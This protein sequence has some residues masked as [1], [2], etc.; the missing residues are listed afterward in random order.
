MAS[1][2][3][4]RKLF[5]LGLN[6]EVITGGQM[7][8]ALGKQGALSGADGQLGKADVL[9]KPTTPALT[10]QTKTAFE[11]FKLKSGIDSQAKE[12]QKAA[13]RALNKTNSEGIKK[14]AMRARTQGFNAGKK[15]GFNAGQ[16]SVGV[17]QGM[18]NTWGRMGTAG[19]IGTAAAGVAATGLALKGLFGG[20]KD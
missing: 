19:K 20:K 17:M 13:Q 2:V 3:L 4:K 18:K 10:E 12:A 15:Q 11:N 8:Q 16:R 5:F 7:R 1:F 9:K 6:G 14:A